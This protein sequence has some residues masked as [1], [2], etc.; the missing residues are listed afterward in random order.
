MNRE[1]DGWIQ[2]TGTEVLD[3]RVM[4]DDAEM[5]WILSIVY[6]DVIPTSKQSERH[7]HE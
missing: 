6:R 1:T 2:T 5:N 3:V 4:D 7:N